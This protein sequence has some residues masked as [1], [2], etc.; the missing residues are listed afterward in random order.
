MGVGVNRR[1]VTLSALSQFGP[2][3]GWASAA[4]RASAGA[5]YNQQRERVD[6]GGREEATWSLNSTVQR[7]P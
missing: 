5:R 3:S 4:D 2:C 1:A 7:L 6:R